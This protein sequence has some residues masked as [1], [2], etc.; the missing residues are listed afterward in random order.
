MRLEQRFN[1]SKS[2]S[3]CSLLTSQSVR[4]AY[5]GKHGSFWWRGGCKH[6]HKQTHTQEVMRKEPVV[7]S[8]LTVEF[9]GRMFLTVDSLLMVQ[10]NQRVPLRDYMSITNTQ[11]S[12]KLVN[13]TQPT[14]KRTMQILRIIS[15]KADEYKHLCRLL[16]KTLLPLKQ[17]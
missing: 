9:S 14:I 6:T 13:K 8:R 11:A 4:G 10:A 16:L 17:P 5:E 3:G 7:K 15:A 1:Y 12:P 2:R